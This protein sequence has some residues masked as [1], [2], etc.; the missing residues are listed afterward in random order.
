MIVGIVRKLRRM[1]DDKFITCDTL[2]RP[3]TFNVKLVYTAMFIH[4][5]HVINER[6]SPSI[7]LVKS[8][9]LPAL[10]IAKKEQNYIH[11]ERRTNERN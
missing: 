8:L 3:Q 6:N 1:P 5:H 7:A 11:M 10:K 2:S 9:Y 4:S